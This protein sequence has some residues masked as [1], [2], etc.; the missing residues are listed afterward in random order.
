M[1]KRIL[2][3]VE[4]SDADRTILEHVEQL[5][6]M[7]GASIVLLHV[8]DGWAAR[9]YDELKLRES[10]EM[11]E[12][13]G[14]LDRLTAELSG[15]GLKVEARLALGDPARQIC[16]AVAEEQVDL[17]AM[18]THGHRGLADVFLG[19]TVDQVRHAVKYP[20]CC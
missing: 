3:P 13:R 18:A 17:I 15:R 11:R 10:E 6:R 20:C 19:E 8:A 12:D 5:A 9:A 14:Y 16:R 2:V 7:T 4:N 1:Y